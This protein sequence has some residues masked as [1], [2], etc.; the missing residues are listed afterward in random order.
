[1]LSQLGVTLSATK[2]T[3]NYFCNRPGDWAEYFYG[4]DLDV[5][6]KV[7]F[8]IKVKVKN[9]FGHLLNQGE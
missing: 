8:D 6:F 5:V 9:V 1:M 3:P 4:P 7:C 2:Q